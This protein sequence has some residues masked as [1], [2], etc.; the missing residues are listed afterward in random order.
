MGDAGM[1]THARNVIANSGTRTM[2][3]VYSIYSFASPLKHVYDKDAVAYAHRTP[4]IIDNPLVPE[5]LRKDARFSI[6]IQVGL[7]FLATVIALT[8]VNSVDFGEVN[9]IEIVVASVTLFLWTAATVY[10]SKHAKKE[11]WNQQ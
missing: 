3:D 1:L 6:G 4:A 9:V 5:T 10:H 11:L 2:A 7:L 8:S